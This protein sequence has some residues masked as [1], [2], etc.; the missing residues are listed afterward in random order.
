MDNCIF[1]K[2]I[3]KQ[4]PSNIV[5]EN[6]NC[7]AFKDIHP[8][9]D[10]HILVIPKKHIVSLLDIDDSMQ[11]ELGQLMLNV[12]KVAKQLKLDGY[13]VNI[14]N[15]IKGGQEIFHLHVHLLANY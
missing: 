11:M 12:S 8:K 6:D 5:Y 7:I 4:I 2:I 14:N 13:K 1:C 10:V 3:E 9:A 15:G